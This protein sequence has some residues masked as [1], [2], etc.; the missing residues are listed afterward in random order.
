MAREAGLP[1]ETLQAR[2]YLLQSVLPGVGAKLAVMKPGDVVRR[3][4]MHVCF[5]HLMIAVCCD[6]L[7]IQFVA[8]NSQSLFLIHRPSCTTR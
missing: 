2:M 8:V 6:L 3:Q 5:I 1:V 4:N 7:C